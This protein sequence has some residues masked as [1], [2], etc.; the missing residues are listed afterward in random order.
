MRRGQRQR[1]PEPR[2]HDQ[3]QGGPLGGNSG[4]MAAQGVLMLGPVVLLTPELCGVRP[5]GLRRLAVP[6]GLRLEVCRLGA[7]CLCLVAG[8]RGIEPALRSVGDCA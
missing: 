1:S 3:R 4:N 7:L 2:E 5:G 6:L 8:L